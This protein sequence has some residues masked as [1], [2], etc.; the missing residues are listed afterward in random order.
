MP[1]A[2]SISAPMLSDRPVL[3]ELSH[4]EKEILLRG[5]T[6]TNRVLDFGSPIPSIAGLRYGS[7]CTKPFDLDLFTIDAGAN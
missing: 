1:L 4:L 2:H 5:G 6:T 3:A 7:A